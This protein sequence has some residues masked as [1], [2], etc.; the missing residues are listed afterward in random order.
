MFP[1]ASRRCSV[2]FSGFMLN[3]W[4]VATM[5]ALVAGV[6]GFFT[7]LR[8]SAFVAHA[9]PQAG[10][11]GAA[12]ASLLGVSTFVGLGAFAV[13][14][15]LAIG[16]LGRRG[17]HDAITALVLVFMLG[18]GALFLSWSQEY[19]SAIY[20]LLFGEVLGVST[21]QVLTTAAFGA[22]TIGAVMIFFRP[23]LLSSVVPEVAE[24]RGVRSRR[25]EICFLLIVAVATT[26]SVPVVGALLM[27]S[28]MIGAPGAA[29][30]LT[31]KPFVALGLSVAISL[32]IVW[33]AIAASYET[34]WP[35][36]FYVGVLGAVFFL[37]A[38]SW[39]A[40]RL[41]RVGLTGVALQQTRR[42]RSFRS[43]SATTTGT[44]PA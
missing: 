2:M 20:A 13:L 24:A 11:A 7:V 10:F 23:L 31:A 15:A 8:G 43:A 17:R 21:N 38:R 12:G 25:M 44:G 27:F 33:I 22:V 1:G 14:S 40:W 34:D 29:R 42:A 30:V 32:T 6:V 18:L 3:A 35:V 9:V 39:A 37:A 16:L 41:P 28:L 5:V 19:A 4:V 26:M 36:G